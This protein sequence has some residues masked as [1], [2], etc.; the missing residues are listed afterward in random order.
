[1]NENPVI[2]LFAIGTELAIGQIQDTNSSWIAQQIARMGGQPRRLTVL[3]DDMDDIVRALEESLARNTDIILLNGG[4]GPTPDDMTVDAICRF[5][6]CE[7]AIHEPTI[8][9]YMQR[10]DYKNRDEVSPGLIKMGTVPEGAEA[11]PNPAGWAPLIKVKYDGSTIFILAGPPREMQA[12][13]NEYVAEFL[14][15]Q[16]KTKTSTCRVWT[17]MF[18]SEVSPHLQKVM[19]EFP[20]TYLKAYVALRS[21][22]KDAMPVDIVA[23]GTD[24]AAAAENMESAMNR[25]KELVEG[26]GKRFEKD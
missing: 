9:D 22:D 21:D 14:S 2:E 10:R 23:H 13:F 25:F 8:E 20:G 24:E 3:N 6:G 7:S 11:F 17:E 18:E 1:M 16:F 12:V 4:L 15:G 5:I 26:A 19:E